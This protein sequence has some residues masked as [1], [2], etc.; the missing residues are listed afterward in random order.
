MVADRVIKNP[1]HRKT[2]KKTYPKDLFDHLF[3]V[4]SPRLDEPTAA[5]VIRQLASALHYAHDK[6][7]AHRDT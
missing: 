5:A 1:M 2:P 6:G 7:I 4:D 3:D